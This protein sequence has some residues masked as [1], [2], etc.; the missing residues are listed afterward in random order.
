MNRLTIA[1]IV[2][3]TIGLAF[4]G[5]GFANQ[6]KFQFAVVHASEKQIKKA[7]VERGESLSELGKPDYSHGK[8]E[9]MAKTNK[10]EY[11]VTLFVTNPEWVSLTALNL[12]VAPSV[13]IHSME[14]RQ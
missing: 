11:L 1:G 14:E 5:V 12:F 13:T 9:M 6:S 2:L 10:A 7:F 3:A 8:I 4:V